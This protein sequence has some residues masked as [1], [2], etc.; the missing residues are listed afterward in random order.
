MRSAC[1][2]RWASTKLLT[3]LGPPATMKMLRIMIVSAA[4]IEL[5]KPTPMSLRA[6][7]ASGIR[8]GSFSASSCSFVVMS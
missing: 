1:S 8:S 2:G 3:H 6:P 4:K 7:A 5:T